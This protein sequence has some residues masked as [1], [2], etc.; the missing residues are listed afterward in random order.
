MR[1]RRRKKTETGIRKA[2]SCAIAWYGRIG[3]VRDSRFLKY[4]SHAS[5]YNNTHDLA[6]LSL[7]ANVRSAPAMLYR[8]KLLALQFR[9]TDQGIQSLDPRNPVPRTMAISPIE[10]PIEFDGMCAINDKGLMPV[11]RQLVYSMECK[12]RKEFLKNS[13]AMN[14]IS[15]QE[16][17][18]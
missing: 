18:I 3:S 15:L 8:L 10:S 16:G 1:Y 12:I 14:K 13:T 2:V 4:R 11:E 9:F 7:A 17:M 6:T 5:T